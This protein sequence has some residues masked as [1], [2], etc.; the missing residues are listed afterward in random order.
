MVRPH[1]HKHCEFNETQ[2]MRFDMNY[3]NVFVCLP[4]REFDVMQCNRVCNGVLL[5]IKCRTPRL[6]CV[7]SKSAFHFVH[8]IL[9][10]NFARNSCDGLMANVYS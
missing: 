9:A 7:L 3:N 6:M 10:S 2:T 8:V 5:E 4:I 1:H